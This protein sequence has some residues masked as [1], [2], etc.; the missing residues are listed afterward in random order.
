MVHPVLQRL[1]RAV[2]AVRV[3]VVEKVQPHP[4]LRS[5]ERIRDEL[6]PERR[7]ADAH[8]EHVG[9]I[10][11]LMRPH[12]ELL[13]VRIARHDFLAQHIVRRDLRRAQPVMAD[14]PL[15]VRIR[16][17][18]L[19]QLRHRRERLLHRGLHAGEPR[20]VEPHPAHIQRHAEF[21]ICDIRLLKFSPERIGHRAVNEASPAR[22]RKLS[23]SGAV[24]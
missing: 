3:R 2:N 13:D 8:H 11:A 22:P 17:R 9:K 10:P 24:S 4:V 16:D 12:R 1:E 19:F 20:I 6:R 15:L 7:A 5:P 18:A 21:L 14:H 23:R